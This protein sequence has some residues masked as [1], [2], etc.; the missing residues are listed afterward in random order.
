MTF[1]YAFKFKIPPLQ[2]GT[3]LKQPTGLF[4]HGRSSAVIPSG[5]PEQSLN[6]PIGLYL[7]YLQFLSKASFLRNLAKI[8]NPAKAGFI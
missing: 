1:R 5:A 2:A 4:L 8:N 7:F 3:S 6:E